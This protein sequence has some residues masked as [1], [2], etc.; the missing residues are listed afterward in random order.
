MTPTLAGLTQAIVAGLPWREFNK[1]ELMPRLLTVA[2]R[3]NGLKIADAAHEAILS[4]QLPNE[5]GSCF[6]RVII[7]LVMAVTQG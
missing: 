6:A 1:Y 7:T 4:A 5:L 2:A 3:S